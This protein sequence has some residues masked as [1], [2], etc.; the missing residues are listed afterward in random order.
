MKENWELTI[1]NIG[2]FKGV[3]N[4]RLKSGLNILG[5]PNASGKTSLINSIRLLSSPRNELDIGV[6]LNSS[7][8]NGEIRLKYDNDYFLSISRGENKIKILDQKLLSNNSVIDEIAFLSNDNTFIQSIEKGMDLDI[9]YEWLKKIT[10]LEYYEKAFTIVSKIGS[11]YQLQLEK[12]KSNVKIKE[13]Q[14]EIQL[15]ELTSKKNSLNKRLLSLRKKTK[16]ESNIEDLKNQHEKIAYEMSLIRNRLRRYRGDLDDSIQK[17]VELKKLEEKINIQLE[18]ILKVFNNA[19]VE[20]N[21]I[22]RRIAKI[23]SDIIMQNEKLSLFLVK[24][25]R[26]NI[27]KEEISKLI[28]DDKENCIFCN[29]K[30]NLKDLEKYLLLISK[31]Q[32][33][34]NSEFDKLDT[35]IKRLEIKKSKMMQEIQDFKI[36]LPRRKRTLEIEI[37]TIKSKIRFTSEII[38]EYPGKILLEEKNLTDFEV[39]YNEIQTKLIDLTSSDDENKKLQNNLV[40]DIKEVNQKIANIELELYKIKNSNQRMVNI[41][42]LLD[43][44]QIINQE[45]QDKIAFIQDEFIDKINERIKECY[46]FLK[47]LDFSSVILTDDLKLIIKRKPGIITNFK[48]LSTMERILIGIIISYSVLRAFYPDFPIFAIDDPLNA[49]DDIRFQ[50]LV[51]YLSTKIPLLI[52]TRNL[53]NDES[54]FK[55]I[56][57][58]NIITEI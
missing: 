48:E 9:V 30:L 25:D 8:M 53:A 58:D 19:E 56:T 55:I 54:D 44:I 15:N 42:K 34:L 20:I 36:N 17:I 11:E 26:I 31:E 29:S 13:S 7:S 43:V 32:N 49:A 28:N 3:H 6:Y 5:A 45:I 38:N 52:V 14:L 33:D 24:V 40:I 46:K 51:E 27:I 1:S 10:D 16:E 4:F 37:D 2:V 35:L 23:D 57:Q 22:E 21:K 12:L 47:F 41:I 18:G 50:K 39:K